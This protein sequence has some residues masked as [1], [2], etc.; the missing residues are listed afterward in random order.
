MTVTHILVV[1]SQKGGVGKTA[2]SVNLAVALRRQGYRVLLVDTDYS[3][4]SVGFHLGMQ[5][6]NVGFQS[7]I[8]GKAKLDKAVGIH[9]PSGL[10]VLPGEISV[11]MPRFSEADVRSLVKSLDGS[12][13]EF[14]VLDTAPGPMNQE[15]M[16]ELGAL[17]AL[18][19]I[20]MTPEMSATSSAMR[21]AQIYSKAHLNY[22]FIANKIGRKRYELQVSEIEDALG[23]RML[24]TLP[25]DQNVPMSVAA[26]IPLVIYNGRS[27]FAVEVKK[28]SKRLISRSGAEEA[29]R[30][31]EGE[32]RGF[33]AWLLG[34]FRRG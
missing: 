13:Y 2:V 4:P 25:E 3:N 27:P 22:V 8:K 18:Q 1:C 16:E 28:L 30:V 21:L 9:A 34:F 17:K 6:T 7:V 23:E 15:A 5:D 19:V 26:H 31:E 29:E 11:N 33:F 12:G 24:A 14:A 20:I 32:H 10:H